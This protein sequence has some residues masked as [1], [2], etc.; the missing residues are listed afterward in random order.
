[1]TG[2]DIDKL[3]N[4][5]V[6]RVLYSYPE[7]ERDD[8]QSEGHKILSESIDYYDKSKGSL[9]T[10]ITFKVFGGLRDYA[11]RM[12]S[13]DLHMRG[14][15]VMGIPYDAITVPGPEGTVEAKITL[16][17]ILTSTSGVSREILDLMS[18]G[19]TQA[20]CAREL[21]ISRARVTQL[22]KKIREEWDE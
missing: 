11:K 8:L 13:R 1:M 18:K 3:I 5:L 21:G 10:F 9:S 20:E 15:R 12:I 19:Y 14:M 17:A 6:T 7:M 22:L 2:K 16:E 4:S